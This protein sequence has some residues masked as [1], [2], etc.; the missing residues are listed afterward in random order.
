MVL[1]NKLIK[2]V[3]W[4]LVAM[5]GVMAVLVFGNVVLA[6]VTRLLAGKQEP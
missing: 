4:I 2:L 3:E 5:F 6:Q 1:L